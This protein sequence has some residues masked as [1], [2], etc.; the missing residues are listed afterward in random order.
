MVSTLFGGKPSVSLKKRASSAAEATVA[1][2]RSDCSAPPSWARPP[3]ASCCTF[4]SWR[5]TSAAVTLGWFAWRQAQGL[6]LDQ[7]RTEVFTLTVLAQWF[8]VL[9][10]RSA[11]RSALQVSLLANPWLLGGLLLSVVL[12]AG[13]LFWPPLAG[14]FHAVPL[15]GPTLLAIL[16]VASSVLWVEEVRKWIVRSQARRAPLPPTQ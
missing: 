7:V 8:N 14:L 13:V 6:P 3:G 2:V 5:E 15:S 10:C 9:N 16:G 1:M 11:R 12:Q 4:F